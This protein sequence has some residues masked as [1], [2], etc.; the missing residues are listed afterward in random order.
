MANFF[1]KLIDGPQ[2]FPICV[3]TKPAKT[4]MHKT[5]VVRVLTTT[6]SIHIGEISTLARIVADTNMLAADVSSKKICRCKKEH[7]H[8][9]FCISSQLRYLL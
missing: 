1:K 3:D 8:A 4:C 9:L 6:Q 7:I 2:Y 5:L